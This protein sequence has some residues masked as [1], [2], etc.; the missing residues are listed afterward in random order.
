MRWL[1]ERWKFLRNVRFTAPQ[2]RCVVA[3]NVRSRWGERSLMQIHAGQV[4][5]GY[6]LPSHPQ[7]ATYNQAVVAVDAGGCIEI[8]GDVW[9][10][11]GAYIHVCEGARLVLR[12]G[13]WLAHN[14]TLIVG[15]YMEFGDNVS[16]GWN[17]TF[18]DY[19]RRTFYTAQGQPIARTPRPLIFERNSG[20]QMHVAIPQG[21]RV[22]ENAVIG[23]NTVVRQDVPAHSL[24]YQNPE[25]QVKPNVTPGLHCLQR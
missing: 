1:Y 2:A 12:G 13:N 18:I 17:C 15:H 5:I 9:I 16:I 24:V 20:A 6:P 7:R 23:S 22:G 8:H 14:T 11:P 25:L 3:R 21:V 10:A 19:D 4:S